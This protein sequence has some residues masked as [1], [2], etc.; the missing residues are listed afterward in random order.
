MLPAFCPTSKPLPP[1]RK[2]SLLASSPRGWPELGGYFNASVAQ[3]LH[4]H[5]KWPA[6]RVVSETG[7]ERMAGRGVGLKKLAVFVSGRGSNFRAIHEAAENGVVNGKVAVL[8]TD[9]YG[10][11]KFPFFFFFL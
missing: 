8:V 9:K 4:L 1:L 3:S 5:R 10:M 11:R 2:T 6:K 7:T